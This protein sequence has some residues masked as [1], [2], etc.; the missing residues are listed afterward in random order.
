M[1]QI[2]PKNKRRKKVKIILK[3]ISILKY[4]IPTNSRTKTTKYN[5]FTKKKLNS[6]LDH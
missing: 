4:K 5:I 6:Y 1:Q 3:V 2:Y